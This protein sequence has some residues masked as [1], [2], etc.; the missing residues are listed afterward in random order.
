MQNGDGVRVTLFVD[1]CS[2]HCEGCHNPI[3]WEHGTG[4]PL[5]MWEESL[6]FSYLSKDFV[7]GLTLTGGD[8]FYVDN[9]VDVTAL[10]KKF[11][12]AFPEKTLW[13][14]TGYTYSQV[15][16]MPELSK[17]LNLIDVLV[18]GPYINSLRDIELPWRGS[19]NQHVIDVQ[20]SLRES[21][22]VL[23]CK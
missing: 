20:R 18:D 21:Q 12:N 10:A 13:V 8:P 1:G 6:L 15:I 22:I 7:S 11:K 9:I 3:T 4:K 17:V 5:D 2:H 23:H 14:W 19:A 16:N